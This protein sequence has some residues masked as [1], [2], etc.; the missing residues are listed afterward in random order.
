MDSRY[1]S[2]K[3]CR[4]F[5]YQLLDEKDFQ[6]EQNYHSEFRRLH[7]RSSHFW[8]IAEGLEVQEGSRQSIVVKPGVAIDVEGREIVLRSDA[9]LAIEALRPDTDYFLEAAFDEARADEGDSTGDDKRNNRIA[10]FVVFRSFS[11]VPKEGSILLAK[12]RLQP[13]KGLLIDTSVRIMAGAKLRPEGVGTRELAN[14]CVT[15]EKLAEPVRNALGVQGWVTI[16][17]KLLGYPGAENQQFTNAIGHSFCSKSGGK[18]TME[19]PVPPGASK[20]RQFRLCGLSKEGLQLTLRRGGWNADTSSREE[21]DILRAVQVVGQ[22]FDKNFPIDAAKQTLHPLNHGLAV[23][24]FAN[25]ETEIWLV[26]AEF[27]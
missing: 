5:N 22:P 8:G 27:A 3:R 19:I 16:L 15:L 6:D 4:Y 23:S 14:K 10:E 20:I 18:G 13:Q 24:I 7:N 2:S 12:L 1:E 9:V 25:G 17:P 21:T 11:S 26:A